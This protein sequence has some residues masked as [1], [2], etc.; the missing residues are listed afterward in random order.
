MRAYLH[1]RGSNEFVLVR[2]LF[3]FSTCLNAA[4]E[5]GLVYSRQDAIRADE[6]Q[7]QRFPL[8]L[9]TEK[10][11]LLHLMHTGS[12]P[13]QPAC[14]KQ[15]RRWVRACTL[16]LYLT[17]AGCQAE[18]ICVPACHRIALSQGNGFCLLFYL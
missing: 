17:K 6:V 3:A 18:K 10:K 2:G 9:S 1:C 11:P 12:T 4:G 16:P 8:K 14:S 7:N 13:A 5:E 15:K